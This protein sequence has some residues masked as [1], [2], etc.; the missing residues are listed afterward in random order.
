MASIER[1]FRGTETVSIFG[2][3]SPRRLYK[4]CQ[5]GSIKD[6]HP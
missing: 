5:N 6:V 2:F 1:P 3:A 4:N